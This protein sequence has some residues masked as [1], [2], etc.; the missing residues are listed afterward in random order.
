LQ[1][2]IPFGNDKQKGRATLHQLWRCFSLNGADDAWTRDTYGDHSPFDYAQG[3]DDDFSVE[4]KAASVDALEAADELLG[5]G[6]AGLGPKEAAADA[7][8]FFDRE[9]EG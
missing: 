6:F 8:V 3:Q 1:T 5:E 9:G 2:Q 4:V 7:A